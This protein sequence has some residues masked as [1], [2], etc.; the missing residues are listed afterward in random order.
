MILESRFFRLM[1]NVNVYFHRFDVTY[2]HH[3]LHFFSADHWRSS[4]SVPIPQLRSSWRISTRVFTGADNTFMALNLSYPE[5][6]KT[7][8]HL[9]ITLWE[10]PLENSLLQ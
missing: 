8:Q 3:K 4:H 7:L 5:L 10:I 2:S 6:I 1:V 9:V